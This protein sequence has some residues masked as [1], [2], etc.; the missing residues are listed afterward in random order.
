MKE[1]LLIGS[2]LSVLSPLLALAADP[3]THPQDY[4]GPLGRR[5]SS[6]H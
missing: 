6:G 2:G 4:P 1:I 5:I 3:S